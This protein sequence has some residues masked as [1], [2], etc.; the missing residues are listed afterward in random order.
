MAMAN[1]NYDAIVLGAGGVGSAALWQ[2]ARRGLRVLGID[3]FAPPHDRGSSHG[4]TRIIRQAYFEHA[5]YVPLLGECYRMWEELEQTTGQELKSETGL[6]EI[7]PAD[8][9]VVP[10]VLRAAAQH[11][12]EVEPLSAVEIQRRWP[13][14]RVPEPLVGVFERRG[15]LLHVERCVGAC[16]DAARLA[17][18]EL[19]T[20]AEVLGWSN[21][22]DLRVRTSAGEFLTE[23]LIVAAGAW[24]GSLLRNLGLRLEV[25]RK[26]LT[27]HACDN[28]RA[29]A[30]AGFPCYLFEV[31][32]GVFYGFPAL[33]ARGLKAGEHSGGE[34]V[35]DPLQVDRSVRDSDRAPVEAFLKSHVPTARTPA[36]EHAVCMYTMSPDEHFIVDRHPADPRVVFAAGL[37]GHGFKFTPVLGRTLAELAFD[38]AATLPVEFLSLAP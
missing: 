8:G 3:R 34:A 18:A 22:G 15:G 21:D 37:S 29:Q 19:L 31:P 12:L 9:E 1:R 10:G 17:G 7:G 11:G 6:V 20:G 23:R 35:A 4:Q 33:D 38:G 27:W 36:A 13:T 26:V 30:D 2:L 16:L 25:R 5:D 28:A 32:A 14:L 24:A